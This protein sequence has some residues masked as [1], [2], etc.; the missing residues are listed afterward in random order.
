M[1]HLSC[2]PVS[3]KRL[4]LS[5]LPHKCLNLLGKEMTI[6]GTVETITFDNEIINGTSRYTIVGNRYALIKDVESKCD[7]STIG[8]WSIWGDKVIGLELPPSWDEQIPPNGTLLRT[9]GL[10][11]I[12]DWNGNF[13]PLI[14]EVASFETPL[15]SSDIDQMVFETHQLGEACQSD[16]E[17][18]DNLICDRSTNLCAKSPEFLMRGSTWHSIN[19]AC[20]RDDDCPLGQVCF[21][22]L[23]IGEEAGEYSVIS[24]NDQDRG[25]HICI[26]Q[27]GESLESLCPRIGTSEDLAGQRYTTGK[28]VCIKGKVLLVA[29]SA[30]D[31]EF[32]VQLKVEYPKVY[33]DI[34]D[35]YATW[36]AT[37]EIAPQYRNPILG[38]HTVEL[39]KKWEEIIILGTYRFDEKHGWFEVHPVKRWWPA[40]SE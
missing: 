6:E 7:L 35:D 1:F 33:P 40:D 38:D 8:T 30:Q 4:V 21:Q 34:T 31:R 19:G 9:S 15:L 16:M 28:E 27:D 22:P 37:T 24:F 29:L 12:D 25:K 17:C 13:V 36:G 23:T 26:P 10:F 18:D 20:I 5:Q 11:T 14:R 3:K 32:H 2:D 39:P